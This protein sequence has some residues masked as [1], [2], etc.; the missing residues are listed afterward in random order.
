MKWPLT[1]ITGGVLLLLATTIHAQTVAMSP[2]KLRLARMQ[3]Q[4][5]F[6]NT[7][8][9]SPDVFT[10]QVNLWNTPMERGEQEGASEAML[11]VVE[12]RAEGEGFVPRTRKMQLTARYRIED[13]SRLGKPAFF[14]RTTSINIGSEDKF[15]GAFWVSGTGCYPVELTARIVGQEGVLRKTINMRCGSDPARGRIS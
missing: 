5:F 4:L 8:K 7:G 15:F 11:V 6:E 2:Q 10:N 9:F 12:I 1:V 3:A 14:N 13:G